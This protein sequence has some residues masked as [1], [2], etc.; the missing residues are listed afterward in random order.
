MPNNTAHRPIIEPTDRSM[1]PVRI[2]GVIATASRPISTECLNTLEK[3]LSVRK[4]RPST[5][6]RITSKRITNTRTAS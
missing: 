3:F 5:W 6:N 1:P 4:F 2:T